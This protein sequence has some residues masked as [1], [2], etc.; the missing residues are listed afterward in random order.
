MVHV[1]LVDSDDNAIGTMEKMEAH[2][3]GVLHRALS[4]IVFN[5]RREILLQKRARKKYHSGGLWTNTCCSH[6]IP[7]ESMEEAARR[8]LR[9]EMGL[10]L[11]PSFAYA[12]LYEAYLGSD[13]TEHEFDHVFTA[14]SELSPVINHE[15]VEDWKWIDVD[16]LRKDVEANPEMYSSWF[17]IMI[18]QEA[19]SQLV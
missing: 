9:H 19:F 4:V 8:T 12:F 11:R 2:Q 16:T 15:E 1:I 5:S 7:G 17:R 6:P 18:G 14:T 3:K 10:D 13:L